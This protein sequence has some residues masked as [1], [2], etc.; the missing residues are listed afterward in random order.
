MDQQVKQALQAA[1]AGFDAGNKQSSSPF[2]LETKKFYN[3]LVTAFESNNNFLKK[4]KLLDEVVD[5][6]P[7]FDGVREV[8]FDLLMINF[9]AADAQKLEE[10]YLDSP[11][12]EKIEDETIDRGTEFLNV[13]LYLKECREEDIDPDLDDYLK[14]FLLIDEDEFQDEHLIYE[15]VIANELLVEAEIEEIARI[16]KNI[17][18]ASD[19]KEIFYPFMTYFADPFFDEELYE[20]FIKYSDNKS[21]DASALAALYAY[22]EGTDAFPKTFLN[23]IN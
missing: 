2:T 11:E 23:C 20:E 19:V 16:A 13:F 5:N 1:V 21:A 7:Y 15:D 17:N 22:Y 9:F 18:P 4:A 6:H 10:D 14:E 3:E 12:W 8:L